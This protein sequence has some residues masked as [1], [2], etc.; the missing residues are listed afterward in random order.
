MHDQHLS[1]YLRPSIYN[2]A[3]F[4]NNFCTFVYLSTLYEGI[5]GV[6]VPQSTATGNSNFHNKWRH[7]QFFFQ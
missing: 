6:S 2:M 3:K 4:I 7:M 1:N 5:Q